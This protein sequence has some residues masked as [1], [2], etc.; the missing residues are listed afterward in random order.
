MGMGVRI[1]V[2]EYFKRLCEGEEGANADGSK[3]R[4]GGGWR[5]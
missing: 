3:V 5:G 1:N 2:G 4:G